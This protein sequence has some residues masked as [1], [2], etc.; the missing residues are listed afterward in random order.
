MPD[1][2]NLQLRPPILD[3]H[4]KADLSADSMKKTLRAGAVLL[5]AFVDDCAICGSAPAEVGG[6]CVDCDHLQDDVRI[7]QTKG[8]NNVS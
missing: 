3:V 2:P 6:L 4:T 7:D 5:F 8:D 1:N